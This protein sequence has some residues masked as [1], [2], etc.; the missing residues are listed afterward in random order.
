MLHTLSDK[1]LLYL[2]LLTAQFLRHELE[3]TTVLKIKK[4][5]KHMERNGIAFC[6]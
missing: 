4:Y 6:L 1:N 3:L 2:F 5:Q